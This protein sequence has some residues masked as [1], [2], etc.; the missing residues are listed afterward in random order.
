MDTFGKIYLAISIAVLVGMLFL[1]SFISRHA[2]KGVL[3][4]VGVGLW[5][6]GQA[7]AGVPVREVRVISGLCILSGFI[8]GLLG[9][10]DIVRKKKEP[11]IAQPPLLPSNDEKMP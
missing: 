8:S 2:P 5:V 10:F 3:L 6:L 1:F 11:T 9:I 7:L 4:A